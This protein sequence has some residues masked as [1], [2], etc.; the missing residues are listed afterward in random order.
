M[1]DPNYFVIVDIGKRT[2]ETAKHGKGDAATL[3]VS[4][5]QKSQSMVCGWF[6]SNCKVYYD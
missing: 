6:K 5:R 2:E 4:E 1:Y 3:N